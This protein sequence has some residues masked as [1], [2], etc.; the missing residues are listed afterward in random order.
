MWDP[1]PLHVASGELNGRAN[2]M[3][4]LAD[5][6]DSIAATPS[7][8][9]DTAVST[10]RRLR[11]LRDGFEDDLAEISAMRQAMGETGDAVSGL[12]HAVAEIDY[13]AQ[14]H[15]FRVADDGGVHDNGPRNEPTDENQRAELARERERMKAELIDR[16]EQVLRRANDIDDDL[17]RVLRNILDGQVTGGPGDSLTS[18]AS[19]GAGAGHLSM[20]EPPRGGTPADNAG[21]YASLGAGEKAWILANRPDLIGNLDGVPAADRDKA[22]RARIP[23]ERERLEQE[24]THAQAAGDLEEFDRI[25]AKL[26]SLDGV[27]TMLRHEDRYLL[28]LDTSGERA[29]AAVA[30]GDVNN[31]DHV[32]VFTPGMNSNVGESMPGTTRTWTN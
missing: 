16:V 28:V 2:L 13:L 4:G 18:A 27:E 5:E 1:E 9:G 8:I 31:A 17:S 12:L 11:L 21:W 32:A 25:E 10:A 19:A 24:R 20:I 23:I 15:T 7:W 14:A 3:L 22:N 29:R 6:M 30:N 26:K